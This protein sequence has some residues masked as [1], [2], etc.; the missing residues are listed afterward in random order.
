MKIILN[1]LEYV[2][3]SGDTFR[4]KSVEGEAEDI[5]KLIEKTHINKYET[6]CNYESNITLCHNPALKGIDISPAI[7]YIKEVYPR[8][9]EVKT[10]E[11]Y[12]FV[13]AF[14]V[15]YEDIKLAS[16][17]CNLVSF[18][19][20]ECEYKRAYD[21]YVKTHPM[22]VDNFTKQKNNLNINPHGLGEINYGAFMQ[23]IGG[24]KMQRDALYPNYSSRIK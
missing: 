10:K 23:C 4:A 18:Y 21:R 17:D 20:T 9:K 3:S 19:Q 1:D 24:H 7:E 15:Y 22:L 16:D 8:Y 12:D 13:L 5:F 14:M 2:L 11:Y 6:S